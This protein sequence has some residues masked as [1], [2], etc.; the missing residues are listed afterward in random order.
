MADLG[1]FSD[2]KTVEF[3]YIWKD[4][5]KL[6][7]LDPYQHPDRGIRGIQLYFHKIP[8]FGGNYHNI[9]EKYI[10]YL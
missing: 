1:N 4:M 5:N 6:G 2:D 3:I 7:V 10:Y 9:P 8:W